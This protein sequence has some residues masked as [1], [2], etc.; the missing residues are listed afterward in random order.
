MQ[1]RPG[2]VLN[3]AAV[4]QMTMRHSRRQF[5]AGAASFVLA[6]RGRARRFLGEE[7]KG[8]RLIL[9][10]TR[11]GPRV[12]AG[13][14]N[15]STLLL[16]N[17]VPYVVDCGAGTSRQLM[18]AGVALNRLRYL[19]FTHLHADHML[20]YGPIVYNGWVTGFRTR[21]DAYGPPPLK[22][23]TRAFWEYVRFD[24]D[25]R[26]EDEGRPDP[27]HLLVANEFDSP[28]ILLQ[29]EDVKVTSAAV[30]HPPIKHAYAFRF[31]TKNRSIVISG[32]TN[33][34]P[35]LV[36]LAKGADVLVH[37]VLYLPSLDK[38]LARVPDASTLRKHLVDSHTVPEDV[39]RVA[40][41]AQVKTVVL[42]HL[43]PGDDPDITDDMWADGVR[44]HFEGQVIV[45]KDLMEI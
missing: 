24:V 23:A 30:V 5:L 41:Q 27:R 33:Y 35:E 44:K 10:G 21:V 4:K 42:S 28:G 22:S 36:K 32:D 45:G 6:S 11:G 43:V 15:P 9:L 12:G 3:S 39:G 31:D 17:G 8:T 2:N 16:I 37:E 14:S 25:T 34:A 7:Q 18:A 1:V 13:R 38:L 19:F 26:I 20:E 29:N 40:A